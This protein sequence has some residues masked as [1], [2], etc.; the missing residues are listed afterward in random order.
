M[1][2][3]R[4]KKYEDLIKALDDLEACDEETKKIEDDLESIK[5]YLGK[6]RNDLIYETYYSD[7]LRLMVKRSRDLLD[8]EIFPIN[9]KNQDLFRINL[10]IKKEMRDLKQVQ[11]EEKQ[12][13]KRFKKLKEGVKNDKEEKTQGLDFMLKIYEDQQRLKKYLE[14]EHKRHEMFEKTKK[15]NLKLLEFEQKIARLK[16][17]NILNKEYT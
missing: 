16:K 3:D 9:G 12:L 14:I 5:N 13:M 17:H 2:L 15:N 10:D 1:F 4:H 8:K 7:T 6:V 11:F